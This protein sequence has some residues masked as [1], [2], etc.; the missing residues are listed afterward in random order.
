MYCSP[1]RW[2]GYGQ[3]ILIVRPDYRREVE[4]PMGLADEI[5]NVIREMPAEDQYFIFK[6]ATAIRAIC[7]LADK[8][9]KPDQAFGAIAV[10]LIGAQYQDAEDAIPGE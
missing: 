6:T 4:H 7:D 2:L 9:G 5:S 10:A 3:L 1:L 8:L